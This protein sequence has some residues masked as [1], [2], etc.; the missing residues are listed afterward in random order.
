VTFSLP[1]ESW[2]PVDLRCMLSGRS[3]MCNLWSSIHRRN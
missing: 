3:G 1:K 2:W